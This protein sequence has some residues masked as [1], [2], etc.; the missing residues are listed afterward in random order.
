MALERSLAACG[1]P[2]DLPLGD[3]LY[4]REVQVGGRQYQLYVPRSYRS[5]R[6]SAL[7]LDFHAWRGNAAIEES[8]NGFESVAE[9]TGFVLARPEAA[10][11]A[12]GPS[13]SLYGGGSDLAFLRA[14]IA[15]IRTTVCIDPARIYAV[16]MSQGG[17]LATQLT[18]SLRGMFA[19]VAS[20]AVLDHPFGCSPRPTP[21]IAF[22][23]RADPIYDIDAGLDPSI[24]NAAGSQAPRGARPGPLKSEAAAWAVTN[25][26]EP[27]P[28]I[29]RQGAG[30]ERWTFRCPKTSET[31]VYVHS[32]GHVW[33]GPWFPPAVAT[34]LALGPTSRQIDA[35]W[36]IWRFFQ[37]QRAH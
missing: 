31:I 9:K 28:T 4:F 23:G 16:G 32:G 5:S 12:A 36:T 37:R 3:D 17:Q 15:D 33:P 25:H 27:N 11:G 26:C 22:V 13:W 1:K 18:C 30:L 14:V 6:A 7:V 8:F 2:S 35:T 20:V 19:A 29:F 10:A 34:Q 21:I 24:F